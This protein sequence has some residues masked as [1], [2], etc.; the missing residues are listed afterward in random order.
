MKRAAGDWLTSNAAENKSN[1]HGTSSNTFCTQASTTKLSW[2]VPS[3]KMRNIMH[4]K[5]GRNGSIRSKWVPLGDGNGS[6]WHKTWQY[7]EKYCKIG[8]CC[9]NSIM[10]INWNQFYVGTT[11]VFLLFSENPNFGVS[12][13]THVSKLIQQL[14]INL[15][16]LIWKTPSK[17]SEQR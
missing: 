8:N 7:H 4:V 3:M 17:G 15:T 1:S 12:I 14:L 13:R 9:W 16:S 5:L 6:E 2:H 10:Q 11:K